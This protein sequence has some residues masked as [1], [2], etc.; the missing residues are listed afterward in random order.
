MTATRTSGMSA[1]LACLAFVLLSTPAAAQPR[2]P[3]PPGSQQPGRRPMTL[4]TSSLYYRKPP[5]PA[6]HRLHDIITII[7]DEKTMVTSQA[8][9]DREKTGK[10]DAVLEDSPVLRNF[11]LKKSPQSSGDPALKGKF[12]TE[13]E[14]EG[15]LK[16]RDG[17]KF[18]IAAEIVDIRP[19]GNLVVEGHRQVQN[20]EEVWEQSIT[21]IVRP[22]SIRD[23]N[24]VFSKD[25]A[26][27]RIHKRELG[28]V[29]DGYRRGWLLRMLDR[30]Q[31]F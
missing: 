14:A 8:E 3:G 21:G 28:S 11:N 30:V 26:A 10:I 5:P 22:T 7:V 15:N 1:I 13:L 12:T 6:E 17:M 29:R 27:M 16:T 31:V 23:G 24:V 9:Y 4:A 25:V 2:S 18:T 20:N 19:N